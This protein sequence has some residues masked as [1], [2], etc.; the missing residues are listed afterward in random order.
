MNYE[1][2]K[3]VFQVLYSFAER[4]RPKP[5]CLHI[6]IGGCFMNNIKTKKLTVTAMLCAMAYIAVFVCRIPIVPGLDFLKYEPKDIVIAL[7]GFIFGPLTAFSISAVVSVVE[8]VTISST[9]FWGLVMNILSSCAFACTA[10]FIYKRKKSPLGAFLGLLA[11]CVG[12]SAVM[13]LWNYL[14]TPIY[15]GFPREQIASMLIPA[16]LPFNLIKAGLNA[17]LTF[18]LYKPVM[19][20]MHRNNIVVMHESEQKS[21]PVGL[22]ILSGVILVTCILIVLSFKGII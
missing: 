2:L 18:C 10:A 19:S 11:G 8:M 7:G 17:A 13:M 12:A 15:T 1:H 14:V 20:I 4:E 5:P 6:N 9:Q 21:R 16:F 22:W 3:D